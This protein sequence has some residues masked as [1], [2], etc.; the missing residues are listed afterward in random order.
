MASSLNAGVWSREL[1]GDIDKEFLLNGI[2]YGFHIMDPPS[3]LPTAVCKNYSS[4]TDISVGH[5][6][7][8]QIQVEIVEGRYIVSKEKPTIISALGAIPKD[9]DTVRLIH[10]CSR[11][12]GSSLNDFS[13]LEFKHRFQSVKDASDLLRP[14]A[15]MAKVNLKSAYRSVPIHPSN[16]AA[17]GLQWTFDGEQ[18]PT[19]LFDTRLPFGSR[20]A[21]GIFHRLTQAVS[22]MMARRGF[23]SLVTYLDDFFLVADSYQECMDALNMLLRLLR[24]LGFSIAWSKVEGPCTCLTFLGIS[25]NS[26]TMTLELPCSKLSDFR[27]LLCSFLHKKRATCRQLQQL[28]GKLNW[29]C[30]VIHGGRTFL[31]RV[32]DLLAPLKCKSH[33]VILTHE[34]REDIRWWLSFLY[35]FNGVSCVPHEAPTVHVLTDASSVGAGIVCGHD[36]AH[37]NWELDFPGFAQLHINEEILAIVLAVCRWAP[38]WM[39]NR[40]LVHTDN[41]VAKYTINKGTSRNPRI[42]QW[43]RLLFWL[44]AAYDF[45]LEVIH[46]PGR[47]HH[48]PDAASRLHQPGQ[49]LRLHALLNEQCFFFPC[50]H[51]HLP[52]HMSQASFS[53]LCHRFGP[54]RSGGPAGFG[55]SHVQGP[56]VC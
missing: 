16:Y 43:L 13:P 35:T 29:A 47:F 11:P 51:W 20:R 24:Q 25:I 30:Q 23:S 34:F 22:R 45:V 52:S 10:D 53:F 49:I 21:P 46:V 5:L 54:H 55:H 19:Y 7:E 15:F 39:G 37:F 8:E 36:W 38:G 14:G 18:K 28:A 32:L 50:Y 17:T 48:L 12:E 3:V 42:M 4:A 1:Q 27:Q 41:A 31:R 26:I 40:I 9:G 56:Y 2:Q 6:V 44:S 33:K